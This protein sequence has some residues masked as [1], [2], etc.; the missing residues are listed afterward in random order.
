[1]EV[2][3]A[4]LGIGVN[5]GLYG[6]IAWAIALVLYHLSTADER[7][8]IQ[9]DAV[10]RGYEDTPHG[11]VVQIEYSGDQPGPTHARVV[12]HGLIDPEKKPLD[13]KIP[14]Y[15]RRRQVSGLPVHD[16]TLNVIHPFRL[17]SLPWS[18]F[19][20]IGSVLIFA[21]MLYLLAWVGLISFTPL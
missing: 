3:M 1:M 9:F 12:T 13:S 4:S 21:S 11:R 8:A 19:M 10:V 6:V 17:T 2:I 15:V 7:S 20:G 14:I 18:I 5:L 16:I